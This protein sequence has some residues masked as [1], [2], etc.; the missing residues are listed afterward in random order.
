MSQSWDYFDRYWERDDPITLPPNPVINKELYL[1]WRSPRTGK[2][3]PEKASNPVWTWLARTRICGYTANKHFD[4]PD[5]LEAGPV[6][7][8]H[9][10]GQSITPLPD[11]R[12]IF[13]AGEHEDHYDP[14]FYIYNDVFVLYPDK[15]FDVYIY[16]R[17][18]FPPTDFHSATLVGDEIIVIGSLGYH[19]Q[20]DEGVTQVFSLNTGDFSMRRIQTSGDM[21]GWIHNHTATLSDDRTSIILSGGTV[22]HQQNLIDNINEWSL[23][24]RSGRWTRLSKHTCQ[25][26]VVFRR[27]KERIHLFDISMLEQPVFERKKLIKELG[28]E[29][30]MNVFRNLYEPDIEH[31]KIPD[32]KDAWSQK[33]IKINE[34]IVRYKEGMSSVEMLIKGELSQDMIDSLV[35]DLKN[36][37]EILERAPCSA[38][39]MPAL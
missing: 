35:A 6:W 33:F 7:S 25:Q 32:D 8:A 1:K 21:P 18:V 24:I 20:R 5:S 37:L 10:F 9:R 39:Q 19:G 28:Y 30:D 22:F 27:D 31:M 17:S 23:D 3:N 36:K 13:V 4:G 12:V 26:W 2:K 34:A 15:K 38:K 16:P 29:P 14:D 11:G